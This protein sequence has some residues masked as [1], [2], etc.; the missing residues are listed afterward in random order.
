ME[1]FPD[2]IVPTALAISFGSTTEDIVDML[3]ECG[4]NGYQVWL[5]YKAA[6]ILAKDDNGH[7]QNQT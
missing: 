1:E 7:I 3:E 4:L 6:Q 2:L 5:T